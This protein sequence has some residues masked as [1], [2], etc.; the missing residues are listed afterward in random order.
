MWNPSPDPQTP[1]GTQP[2]TDPPGQPAN[3]ASPAMTPLAAPLT[4]PIALLL[5]LHLPVLDQEFVDITLSQYKGKY[6][7]LFFYPLGALRGL[8]VG[9]LGCGGMPLEHNDCWRLWGWLPHACGM[10]QA[11]S[12]GECCCE[13]WSRAVPGSRRRPLAACAFG[14]ASKPNQHSAAKGA[15]PA[16]PA[17][18]SADPRCHPPLVSHAFVPCNVSPRGRRPTDFT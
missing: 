2:A 10:G 18:S 9:G 15:A 1:A 8:G 16:S 11:A 4:R 5:P 6:V 13:G 7:V 14:V 17:A 3:P 12:Q